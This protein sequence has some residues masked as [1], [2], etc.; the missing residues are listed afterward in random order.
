MYLILKLYREVASYL[1][2]M[3]CVNVI[4]ERG[5][6]ATKAPFK[7]TGKL[8]FL[9]AASPGAVIVAAISEQRKS[10]DDGPLSITKEA[11]FPV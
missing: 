4:R 9:A 10:N 3:K 11:R 1:Q 5:G 2:I 7:V 8:L 6:G